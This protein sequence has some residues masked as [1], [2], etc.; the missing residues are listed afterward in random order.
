MLIV[1]RGGG[2]LEELW[3]FNEEA[4]ARAIA[5]SGIP[6]ISAVGHETD[7]TIADFAADLRAATPTAAAELAVPSAAELAG[8]L[9]M[10]RQRLRQ[11]LLR[12]SQRGGER[13]AALQ[14]SLA[15]AGPAG[16]WPST[17]SG[18]TC[19]ARPCSAQQRQGTAAHRGA[20]R[21]CTRAC[22]ASIRLA[23]SALPAGARMASPVS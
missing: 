16:S 14:R 18:W 13:L 1:G 4:V 12:R 9:R 19:C 8:Q 7:F 5:A 6:V 2:S 20:A 11:A 21:C 3:A 10:A 23:A 17:R 15:L 22:S